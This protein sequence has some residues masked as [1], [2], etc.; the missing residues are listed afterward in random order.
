MQHDSAVSSPAPSCCFDV[1]TNKVPTATSLTSVT[2]V[3]ALQIQVPSND[4]KTSV[5][6]VTALQIQVPSNDAN[7]KARDDDVVVVEKSTEAMDRTVL[8]FNAMLQQEQDECYRIHN[9]SKKQEDEELRP[10]NVAENDEDFV[11]LP[12][13]P[14]PLVDIDARRQ[15]G[16]WYIELLQCCNVPKEYAL[17]TMM[18][19][20]LFC[21]TRIVNPTTK[22]SQPTQYVEGGGDIRQDR[23]T[24]R[25]AALTVLYLSMK[26]YCPLP[27]S[28]SVLS[29]LS[30]GLH[31]YEEVA[32]MESTILSTLHWR[33]H[34]PTIM[35]FIRTYLDLIQ[36]QLLLYT[37]TPTRC[38]HNT[39]NQQHQQQ[40]EATPGGPTI[41][42]I[43]TSYRPS[44][45]QFAEYQALAS[46]VNFAIAVRPPSEVAMAILLNALE[47]ILLGDQ[48]H[49]VFETILHTLLHDLRS[50]IL[51]HP[52]VY[53]EPLQQQLL[54]FIGE[55][56]YQQQPH[57][58]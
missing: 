22:R 41:S 37:P 9:Y 2:D 11:V 38:H 43:V 44:I 20:D 17:R 57:H 49:E 27:L 13:P 54:A 4:A 55:R 52:L 35:D 12:P 34:P 29:N 48:H 23:G 8:I 26:V 14:A 25:L 16:E 28:P 10:C 51:R 15:M 6:D 56:I 36:H 5:T 58:Y 21:S 31:T 50:I 1:A 3:T 32:D 30:H 19:L 7:I 39:S 40:H 45:L 53:Y 42:S 46:V 47:I 33:I 18:I 24:Y